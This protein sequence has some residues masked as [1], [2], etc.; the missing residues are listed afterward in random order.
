MPDDENDDVMQEIHALMG[1]VFNQGV[2]A[3]GLAAAQEEVR[4]YEREL[5]DAGQHAGQH[6]F[7]L[8]EL[9]NY[10]DNDEPPRKPH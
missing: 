6:F 4:Q 9:L 8:R 10:N 1:A 2:I 3:G 5:Q 7:K